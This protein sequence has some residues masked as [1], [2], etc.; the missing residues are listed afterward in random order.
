[1]ETTKAYY[2]ICETVKLIP[3]GCVASYGQVADYAGLPR[4]ARLVGRCLKVQQDDDVP[5][6]RV[7]R[8]DGRIAFPPGDDIASEQRQRLLSEGVT[9][10]GHRVNMRDFQWAPDLSTILH[11]LRF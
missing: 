2:Q 11:Q 8:S 4:R 9:V 10:K 3:S 6:H 1:M 7:L 5:W